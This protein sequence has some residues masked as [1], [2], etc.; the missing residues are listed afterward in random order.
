MVLSFQVLLVQ[1]NIRP[2]SIGKFCPSKKDAHK[3]NTV[4]CHSSYVEVFAFWLGDD[5]KEIIE[6]AKV[7]DRG[8][9]N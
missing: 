5:I 6:E 4:S 9:C 7:P 1:A 2:F 8:H 3:I